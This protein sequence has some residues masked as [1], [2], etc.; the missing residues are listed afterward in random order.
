MSGTVLDR[1]QLP[2]SIAAGLGNDL[3]VGL[4]ADSAGNPVG[5]ALAATL[6]P[7][8]FLQQSP[9]ADFNG[10]MLSPWQV[11]APNTQLPANMATLYGNGFID[12]GQYMYSI[13]GWDGSTP[14]NFVAA[15]AFAGNGLDVWAQTVPLPAALADV[16]VAFSGGTIIVVGGLTSA[17]QVNTVYSATA[18]GGVVSAWTTQPVLPASL[19]GVRVTVIGNTNVYTVGGGNNALT[20]VRTVYS[21]PLSSGGIGAWTAP[22]ASQFPVPVMFT[23]LVQIAGWLVAIGGLTTGLSDLATVYAAPINPVTNTIGSWRPWPSLPTTTAGAAYVVNGNI[24]AAQNGVNCSSLAVNAGGPANAWVVQPLLNMSMSASTGNCSTVVNG[25]IVLIGALGSGGGIAQVNSVPTISVPLHATGLVNGTKYHVTVQQADAY[26]QVNVTQF[27]MTGVK[28]AT[29]YVGVAQLGWFDGSIGCIP[30]DTDLLSGVSWNSNSTNCN[31]SSPDTPSLNLWEFQSTANGGP[32]TFST[33]VGVSGFA[34][35]AGVVVSYDLLMTAVVGTGQTATA[36]L[37]FYTSAGVYI[38]SSAGTVGNTAGDDL[39]EAF[40]APA[41]TAFATIAV[42]ISGGDPGDVTGWSVVVVSIGTSYLPLSLY[43]SGKTLKPLHVC[44][45]FVNLQPSAWSTIAYDYSGKPVQYGESVVPIVNLLAPNTS[46]FG[47]VPTGGTTA[48][49]P[50]TVNCAVAVVGATYAVPLSIFNS[51]QSPVG[52]PSFPSPNYLLQSAYLGMTATAA[53]DMTTTTAT[54]TSGV[55]VVVGQHYTAFAYFLATGSPRNCTVTINWY[56]AA[57]AACAHPSDTGN[58]VADTTT[59]FVQAYVNAVAPATAAFASI[60]LKVAAAG[61]ASELHFTNLI[62]LALDNS[63]VSGL[64]LPNLAYFDPQSGPG[65]TRTFLQLVYDAATSQLLNVTDISA[66]AQGFFGVGTAADST[67]LTTYAA[68]GLT[69]TQA[70]WSVNGL[71]GHTISAPAPLS[72]LGTSVNTTGTVLFNIGNTIILTA[73]G[74]SDG[75][76]DD[77][78]AYSIT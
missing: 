52:A 56:T 5:P 76:P 54:G 75:Q 14:Q 2:V 51:N 73:A 16:G 64:A 47:G 49:W 39:I 78:S 63:L 32:Y 9:C 8:E 74:W 67:I 29:A 19:G 62:S 28:P 46:N 35:A 55:P 41:T 36:I 22:A 15:A 48:G 20:P 24:I 40:T 23:S 72:N 21:A 27:A 10:V 6:V 60:T 37:N 38:S 66:P 65:G 4:Y 45:D 71:I 43:I 12:D 69:D 61:A 59:Y 53:G 33:P 3:S 70:K 57:G 7:K 1:V 31:V 13:G 42:T 34:V 18:A 30:I 26:S 44:E 50:G 77:G 25:N 17:A 58:I 11:N 68:N